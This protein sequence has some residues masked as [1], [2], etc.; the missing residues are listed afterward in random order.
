MPIVNI[1]LWAGRTAEVKKKLIENV[2]KAVCETV[3]C[4]PQTVIVVLRDIPKEN[5]GQDGKQAV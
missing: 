2:T 3:G 1:D 4:P 5:W